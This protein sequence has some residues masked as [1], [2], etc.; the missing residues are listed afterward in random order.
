MKHNENAEAKA[1]EE[2]PRLGTRFRP[3]LAAAVGAKDA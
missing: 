3:L 1:R 2:I